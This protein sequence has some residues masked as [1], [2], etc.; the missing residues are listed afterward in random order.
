[1]LRHGQV[2]RGGDNWPLRHET[3]LAKVACDDAATD[4]TYRHYR[5]AVA[6]VEANLE[7]VEADLAG[8]YHHGRRSSALRAVGPTKVD[9]Q[10]P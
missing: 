6:T 7:A 3:W 10:F 2:W 9:Q 4:T 8:Y 1:L 5:A